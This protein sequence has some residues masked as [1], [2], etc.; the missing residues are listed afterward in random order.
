MTE[1]TDIDECNM[2]I[3]FCRQLQCENT[4]GTYTCG[5]RDGFKTLVKNNE[6]ACVDENECRNRNVCPINAD[7]KNFPGGFSC[8][9]KNG[10]EGDFCSDIDECST[11]S[12]V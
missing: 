4:V 3:K 10:F 1:C 7:C 2:G 11:N 8:N 9:C 5:C 12:S 6:Y